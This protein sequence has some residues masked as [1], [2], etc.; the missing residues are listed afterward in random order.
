MEMCL[1][2]GFTRQSCRVPAASLPTQMVNSALHITLPVTDRWE[3][4]C[5]YQVSFKEAVQKLAADDTCRNSPNDQ[6]AG[7]AMI[8]WD[9]FKS[10]HGRGHQWGD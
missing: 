10:I 1:S 9:P 2:T 4:L 7:G 6:G 8:A 3:Q 5:P